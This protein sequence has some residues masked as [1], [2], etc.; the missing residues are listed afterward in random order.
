ME[1]LSRGD[2]R[3]VLKFWRTHYKY[4]ED[5]GQKQSANE[6]FQ[7]YQYLQPTNKIS[8]A[9]F[10]KRSIDLGVKE[11]KDAHREVF[12]YAVPLTDLSTKHHNPNRGDHDEG[13]TFVELSLVNIQGL[14]T[15][16]H[17][18]VQTLDKF[19][20]LK[21]GSQK[22]IA[23]TETHLQKGHHLKSEIVKYIPGYDLARG[24]RDIEYDDEAL[25]KCGGVLVA[26]SPDLLSKRVEKYCYSNG[27]CEVATMELLELELSVLTVYRPSGL[28]FS[29]EKFRDVMEKVEEYLSKLREERPH[30]RIIL[31]GDFNFPQWVETESGLVGNAKEGNDRRKRAYNILCNLAIEFGLEQIVGK[32]TRED[33]ILDLIYTD[34]PEL[35]TV[36]KIE[37][38]KP[39]SDHNLITCHIRVLN[40]SSSSEALSAK[41]PEI[42][43]YNFQARDKDKFSEALRSVRWD[44]ELGGIDKIEDLTRYRK[45]NWGTKESEEIGKGRR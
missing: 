33:S 10:Y 41:L 7:L 22:V 25:G 32:P 40:K 29:L 3:I 9:Q 39:I 2:R 42:R 43:Q 1:N 14:L 5:K 8:Y 12:L 31:T 6:I 26:S 38:L 17:N 34:V 30:Y 24:D 27:N 35:I 18:K 44:E 16:D 11:K 36:T 4:G 23:V 37:K 15:Q 45:S 28:N 13:D 20:N 19:L 21:G